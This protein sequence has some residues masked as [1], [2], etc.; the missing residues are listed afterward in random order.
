MMGI[1]PVFRACPNHRQQGVG[2]HRV[3]RDIYAGAAFN[4]VMDAVAR[5]ANLNPRT[6]VLDGL[7]GD[8]NKIG[9]E[10]DFMDAMASPQHARDY[11][12]GLL[13]GWTGDAIS[14][15]ASGLVTGGPIGAI[16]GGITGGLGISS[17]V[18]RFVDSITG[19]GGSEVYDGSGM[20]GDTYS[21]DRG[22]KDQGGW[23]VNN[24]GAE[25]L[26]GISEAR[27]MAMATQRAARVAAMTTRQSAA[28]V[29]VPG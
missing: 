9:Q 26:A 23:S 5:E 24:L 12:P 1:G 2:Q 18:D 4:D 8:V 27:S 17:G 10:G 11:S 21:N 20:A 6:D 3:L 28:G 7:R 22:F 13:E 25:V 15:A 19:R 14:G 16:L 29:P